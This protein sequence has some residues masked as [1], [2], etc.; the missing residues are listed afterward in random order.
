M[1]LPCP[2]WVPQ[3]LN[4]FT[5]PEAHQISLF[6]SFCRAQSLAPLPSQEVE[7]GAESSN[8]F[9]TRVFLVT[10]PILSLA[11]PTL[12]YLISVNAGLV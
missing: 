5:K 1:G 8:P 6:R 11:V 3:H 4:V 12:S 10:S 7:D 2:L 9:I